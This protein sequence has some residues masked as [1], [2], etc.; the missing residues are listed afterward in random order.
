MNYVF[1]EQIRKKVY[2]GC[3]L[4]H[5]PQEFKDKVEALKKRLNGFCEVLEFLGTTAG[6]PRDVYNHD[7]NDCVKESDLIVAICDFPSTGLGYE[8]A[9]QLEDRGMPVLAVAH[10]N[11]KVTRLIQDIGKPHYEFL[12]Y[13]KFEDI[14]NMVK[15]RVNNPDFW[16]PERYLGRY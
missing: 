13:G 8:I 6:T 11:S 14:Y 10:K 4:S 9:T 5:A 1:P 12:R 15:E 16:P 2:V 3:A 7:I